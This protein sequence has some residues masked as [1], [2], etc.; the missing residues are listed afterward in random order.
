MCVLEKELAEI[1]IPFNDL[2]LSQYTKQNNKVAISYVR[3]IYNNNNNN[4][5]GVVILLVNYLCT[6]LYMYVCE[7]YINR[8]HFIWYT[9]II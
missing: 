9:R 6:Y 4:Y 7:R 2:I 5:Y 3:S 8:R 1:L